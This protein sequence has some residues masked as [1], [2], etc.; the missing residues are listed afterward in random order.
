MSNHATRNYEV[1]RTI[2]YTSDPAGD[3]RRLS[4]AVIVDNKQVSGKDGKT[5]SVP[6]SKAELTHLTELTQSAVGFD[7][8]RGDVVSV[9]NAPF[10]HP[11][12]VDG[13]Q[14][15]PFW[16]R[17]GVMD[18][19][20]QGLGVLA[21]LL[22]AF[23]LLRPMLRGL[24]RGEKPAA[25][26]PRTLPGP[27]PQRPSHVGISETVADLDDDRDGKAL[28]GRGAPMNYEQKVGLARRMASESPRQ[29]AQI[30]KNWVAADGP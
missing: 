20:K 19:V 28:P 7:A 1:D 30:V 9:I 23:G 4:V 6:L 22:L 12:E 5:E 29:V 11:S 10:R 27:Q 26:A 25:E 21:A 17:P 3:I 13:P 8:K 15:P 16:Q 18:L 14:E 24:L 2:S